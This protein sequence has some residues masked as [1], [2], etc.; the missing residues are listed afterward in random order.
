MPPP[1]T[2]GPV[3]SQIPR[4]ANDDDVRVQVVTEDLD[5]GKRHVDASG[6]HLETH[7]VAEPVVRDV[8]LRAERVTVERTLVDRVISTADA[9]RLFHDAELEIA[10]HSDVPVVDKRAHVVEEVVIKRISATQDRVVHDHVRRMDVDVG[11]LAK[12][13]GR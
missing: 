8:A 12:G 2:R 13:D 4:P 9:D 10:A 11:E 5:V 6:V 1:A 3:E 7:V